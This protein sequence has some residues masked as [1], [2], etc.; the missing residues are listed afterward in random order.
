[1]QAT[2]IRKITSSEIPQVRGL[3]LEI[4]PKA[5]EQILSAEQI[6]HMLEMMYSEKV[7]R[8]DL[9]KGVE[10]YILSHDTEDCGYAAIEKIDG[11]AYKLHKI[12]LSQKLQGK[13]L[14]K[15]LIREMESIVKS[16]GAKYLRL[17]VNRQN[18]AVAFYKSQGYGIVKTEDIDIGQGYFMNDYVME[19]MIS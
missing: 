4:W 19:K 16:R 9:E 6:S 8:N 10:F 14:G 11:H 15:Y 5:F 17:N 2:F 18:N 7:L 3:A 12:Y 1:M 13:G